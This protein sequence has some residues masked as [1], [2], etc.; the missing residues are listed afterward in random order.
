MMDSLVLLDV[1]GRM[2][3][4]AS[5]TTTGYVGFTNILFNYINLQRQVA[6]IEAY[7]KCP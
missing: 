1:S 4:Q 3:H 7:Y 5:K 2:I 6:L